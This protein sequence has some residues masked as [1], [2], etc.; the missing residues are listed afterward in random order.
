VIAAMPETEPE[1]VDAEVVEDRWPNGWLALN[2]GNATLARLQ[3][4]RF[5]QDEREP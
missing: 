2:G 1:P 5:R 3:Y 4:E